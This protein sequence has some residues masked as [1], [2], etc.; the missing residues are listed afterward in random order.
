MIELLNAMPNVE[1]RPS[2][3]RLTKIQWRQQLP[4]QREFL[5]AV[6]EEEDGGY[7]VFAVNIPGV[8]SQGES[9]DEAKVNI[10]EAFLAMLEA[11]VKHGEPLP[12]SYRPVIE[13]GE[14]WQRFW[15]T[16]DG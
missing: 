7:S 1:G 15:I 12:Y 10:K 6:C 4:P 5:A 2:K 8:V 11:C 3:G 13:M 9:V 14:G 16:V